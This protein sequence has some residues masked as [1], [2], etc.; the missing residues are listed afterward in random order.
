[1]N[2]K[3]IEIKIKT[4]QIWTLDWS[5][6]GKENYWIAQEKDSPRSL[7]YCLFKPYLN[8]HA[9]NDIHFNQY[10]KSQNWLAILS[11]SLRH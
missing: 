5:D 10:L 4:P 6:L 8:L 7:I 9:D 11:R 3:G 1:M 2:H